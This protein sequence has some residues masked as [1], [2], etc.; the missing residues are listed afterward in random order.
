MSREALEWARAQVAFRPLGVIS[1]DVRRVLLSIAEH[2]DAA[3]ECRV[4]NWRIGYRA[5]VAPK[6]LHRA[7]SDLWSLGL[8]RS[9]QGAATHRGVETIHR[10]AMR[11]VVPCAVAGVVGSVV[12]GGG[13]V[14]PLRQAPATGFVV[15]V[16]PGSTSPTADR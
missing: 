7:Y 4:S 13:S 16:G 11:P 10:L 14:V 9:V 3:G 2:A 5:G 15:P 1:D 12:A 8:L 6:D